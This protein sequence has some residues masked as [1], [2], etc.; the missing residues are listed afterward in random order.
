M[1]E[2]KPKVGDPAIVDGERYKVAKVTDTSVELRDEDALTR[3]ERGAEIRAPFAQRRAELQKKFDAAVKDAE[4]EAKAK[5]VDPKN[6][7]KRNTALPRAEFD[8]LTAE[9]EE[10]LR[11]IARG[12]THHIALRNLMW[13]SSVEA[14]TVPGRLLSLEERKPNRARA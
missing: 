3:D 6:L 11:P 12:V 1:A 7:I 9:E 10:A 2:K 8:V 5:G 4:E 13:A 14:W